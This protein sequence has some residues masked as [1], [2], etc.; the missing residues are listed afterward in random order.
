MVKLYILRNH[1]LSQRF[2][3]GAQIYCDPGPHNKNIW[4]K[5]HSNVKDE[6]ILTRWRRKVSGFGHFHFWKWVQ[7]MWRTLNS[8]WK[9]RK[10]HTHASSASYQSAK[11]KK[12]KKLDLQQWG[13][14]EIF[15][16]FFFLA[17]E[18][19]ESSFHQ[20]ETKQR[21]SRVNTS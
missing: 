4:R 1:M 21:T 15:P 16:F 10:F 7:E 18:V 6:L 12:K 2:M 11:K 20:D 19:N 3:C 17:T 8:V 5:W 13:F 14:T 9:I